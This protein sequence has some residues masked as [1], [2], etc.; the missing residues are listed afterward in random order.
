MRRLEQLI[1]DIRFDSNQ[2]DTNRFPS[3]RLMKFFNDAQRQIQ[4]IIFMAD[5]G[6]EVF[7]KEA[8]YDLVANQEEYALPSDI[9]AQSSVSYVGRSVGN[10]VD[11]ATRY[12]VPMRKITEKEIRKQFGYAIRGSTLLVSTIPQSGVTNGLRVIYTR[13]LPTLSLRVGKISSFVSGSSIALAAGFLTNDITLYDDF[14]TVVGADG[15]IKQ[16]GIALDGY[17]TGTGAITTSTALTGIAV[18]DYVA[19]GSYA[20]THPDIPDEAESLLTSFVERKIYAVDSSPDI[21]D[22]EIFTQEEKDIILKLFEKKDHDVKYPP[23]VDDTY[24]NF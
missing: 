20:T 17:N 23:I 10:S 21:G 2:E 5:S 22:S 11:G 6:S 7:Q 13:K 24:L 3:I 18:D 14:I 4:A 8:L 9:Y 1:N 15:T 19:V 16:S 12:Y